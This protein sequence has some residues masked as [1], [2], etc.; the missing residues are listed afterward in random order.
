MLGVMSSF[1][2]PSYVLCFMSSFT[3]KA[4]YEQVLLSIKYRQRFFVTVIEIYCELLILKY[5]Y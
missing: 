4:T 1:N 5:N 3:A 2:V